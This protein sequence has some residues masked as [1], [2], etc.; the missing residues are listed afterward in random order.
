MGAL[1]KRVD[2]DPQA[3]E[4]KDGRLFLFYRD[5]A[6]DARGLWLKDRDALFVKAEKA[7]PSLAN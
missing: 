5:P 6:L 7:W 2:V 3:Y 1:G 4:V